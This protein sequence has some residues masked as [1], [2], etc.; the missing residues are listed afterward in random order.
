L[1]NNGVL[2]S[3][4]IRNA[5]SSRFSKSYNADAAIGNSLVEESEEKDDLKSRIFRLRLPK[6]SATTVLEKWIGEGNQMTINELREISK[7]LRRTR[8]YKHALEVLTSIIS[9]FI[10]FS[11]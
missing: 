8:R 4:F 6:R 7:E 5:E 10:G 1:T 11:S 3:N 2:G 9:F